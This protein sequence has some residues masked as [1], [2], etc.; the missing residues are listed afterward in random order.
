MIRK[1]GDEKQVIKGYVIEDVPDTP[2]YATRGEDLC[3]NS[4]VYSS[5]VAERD[6]GVRVKNG[7]VFFSCSC[8]M[9]V[10][11]PVS[12][13]GK[14]GKCPGCGSVIAIPNITV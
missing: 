13:A 8:G 6:K 4:W 7:C 10:K 11:M 14:K 3:Q 5:P 2:I 1:S 9:K 12:Y